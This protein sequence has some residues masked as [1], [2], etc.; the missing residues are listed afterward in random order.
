MNLTIIG[1]L[2]QY[3]CKAACHSGSVDSS[4][5][6]RWRGKRLHHYSG[7][8]C[9]LFVLLWMDSQRHE[10][11]VGKKWFKKTLKMSLMVL[12]F[13][14][15]MRAPYRIVVKTIP[16]CFILNIIGNTNAPL[17]HFFK[18]QWLL[19][20][21]CTVHQDG[22]VYIKDEPPLDQYYIIATI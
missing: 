10:L 4:N 8:V 5:P 17:D 3:M 9:W 6:C 14:S 2:V 19:E 22:H 12:L 7:G 13:V 1:S 15:P 18:V 21:S 11:I 20:G 16:L